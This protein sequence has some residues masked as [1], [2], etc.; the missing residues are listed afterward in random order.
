MVKHFS[1]I[2]LQ[3]VIVLTGLAALA[4]LIWLPLTEGKATNSDLFTI[5]SDPFIIYGYAASAIFFIALYKAF[6]LLGCI[7][8][9]KAFTLNSVRI[10]K[11][12]K[13]CAIA[14]SILI[15]AAGLYIKI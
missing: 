12:I 11:S 9:N 4:I 5:Y 8:Q 3:T 2:F 10:V 14:L 15:I 7:R 13:Y 6:K 1:I